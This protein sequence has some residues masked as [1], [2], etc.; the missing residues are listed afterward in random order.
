MKSL[1][2]WFV[3]GLVVLVPLAT[4]LWVLTSFFLWIDGLVFHQVE[5][6]FEVRATGLGF[7]LAVALTTVA[8]W[9]ASHLFGRWI[10]RI[11][12]WLLRR[13]PLVSAIYGTVK[14]IL[15]AIGGEKKTFERPVVVTLSPGGTAKVLG[16]VTRDDLTEIG[17]PG[18]VAVLLQQSL[19][20]AGNIVIF[21]KSQ[22]RELAVD[23]GKFM[24]FVMSGGLTGNL[25]P[26]T[27]P[28]EHFPGLHEPSA[29]AKVA[30]K[31]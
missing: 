2:H 1:A 31:P 14:D 17:L 6:L 23:P 12:D 26:G 22:V 25:G 4:T 19:N 29:H 8:G 9:F 21:P 3:R 15:Q 24:T 27:T 10:E 30:D 18:E 16:F 11:T 5:H 28:V 13:I 7:A 20:F